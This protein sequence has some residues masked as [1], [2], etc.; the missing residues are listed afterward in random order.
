MEGASQH[1]AGR[2]GCVGRIQIKEE[3]RKKAGQ[4]LCEVNLGMGAMFFMVKRIKIK[5]A[6][7]LTP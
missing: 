7:F 6:W 1:E 2:D 5:R 4:E 3:E